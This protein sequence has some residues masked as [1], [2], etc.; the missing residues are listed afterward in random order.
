[1]VNQQTIIY[2]DFLGLHLQEPMAILW[3]G[4]LALI[5]LLFFQKTIKQKNPKTTNF[6]YFFA[7][8]SISTFLGLLGHL[9]FTYFGFYGKFP[10]WFCIVVTSFYFCLAVLQINEIEFNKWKVLILT[11]GLLALAFSYYFTTFNF[12]AIDSVFSYVIVGC[13]LG[14]K[15]ARNYQNYFL[16][17]GSLWIIPSLLIFGLK[18]NLNIYFNK[19]D[20]SHVFIF[21][22]LIFYYFCSSK[23]INY[24]V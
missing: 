15:L 22:S 14:I 5:S 9:F 11:K 18:I 13:S 23:K 4:L 2:F 20:F 10:S 17:L 24:D 16:L 3:D 8:M 6:R 21:I 12:V 19:D 7:W 1:M